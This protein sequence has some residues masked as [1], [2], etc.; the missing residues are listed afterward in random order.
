MNNSNELWLFSKFSLVGILNTA[1]DFI[2]LF[3]LVEYLH[4]LIIPSKIISYSGGTVNSFALNK[5]WTFKHKTGSIKKQFLFFL[6]TSIVGLLWSILLLYVFVDIMKIWYI[7]SNVI[8][9]I[10]I[11][12]WNFFI[13]RYLTFSRL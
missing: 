4:W 3:F 8:V 5:F 9:T 10:L 6:L 7:F 1:I 13:S 12:L 11:L 2:I